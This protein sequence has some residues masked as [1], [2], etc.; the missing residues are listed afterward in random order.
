MAEIWRGRFPKN[1]II[2]LLDVSREFNLAEST[3]QDLCFHELVQ[4]VGYENLKDLRLG[5]G[6]SQGV[7]VLRDAVSRVCGVPPE[8]V[9]TTQG[10][11]FALYLLAAEMCRPGD[12]VVVFTPCFPPTKGAFV[13]S[14][15]AIREVPLFFEE[16]YAVHV[17]RLRS[18]LTPAT[19][20]VSLATPQNP[21]GVTTPPETIDA[22]LCVMN[23]VAP[24]AIL[25]V[26]ETYR[27]ATYGAS[28]APESFAGR[29]PK[30]ITGAS[31]SKAYGA[32]GLRV[33]RLST[34]RWQATCSRSGSESSSHAG[35]CSRRRWKRCRA[36]RAR[37]T[38]GSSGSDPM[39]A[40][41]A[42]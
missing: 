15:V 23:E 40:R 13:G 21:S 4:L 8:Q 5:Y 22:I 35:G 25:F 28:Q 3:S 18:V 37:S 30:I 38:R 39:V 33:V 42:A 27:D 34:R 17:E 36:G 11:A 26:D 31:V 41:F 2:S 1:D 7:T 29:H 19:K 12:E 16:G 10:T 24:D 6:P 20:L 32:A 9:V 14:G